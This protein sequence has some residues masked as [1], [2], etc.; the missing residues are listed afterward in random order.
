M[1][2]LNTLLNKFQE[3]DIFEHSILLGYRGSISHGTY[4]P[5]DTDDKD[6]MGICIA[7]LEYYLGLKRFEQ[8]EKQLGEWDVVIYDIKKYFNLMLKSNPNVLGLL[9]LPDDLYLKKTTL[10]KLIIHNRDLFVSQQAYKSFVGYAYGQLKRM[11]H[12]TTKGYVGEKRKNLFKKYG[13]NIKNASHLIR[14]LEMGIEF[15]QTGE[16]QVKRANCNYLLDIKNGQYTLEQIIQKA[17]QLFSQIDLTLK[18]CTLP[19]EPKYKEIN[20]LLI[21]LIMS[22]H[23]KF[24]RN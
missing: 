12:I 14:L 4:R 21:Y 9:W 1:R 15:L 17:E 3:F 16:L 18:N 10:G 8:F 20:K 7:P 11:T 19:K 6:L 5:N 13:Y 2:T 23:H 24:N 22:Y